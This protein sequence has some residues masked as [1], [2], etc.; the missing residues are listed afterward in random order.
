MAF[1]DGAEDPSWTVLIKGSPVA[2]IKL[3]DQPRAEEIAE[4]FTKDEYAQNVA[5]ALVQCG[6]K[7]VLDQVKA[8]Y[9][10]NKIEQSELAVRMYKKA[11]A[12]LANA[13]KAALAT[14]K[15]NFKASIAT[16]LAGMNRN[17]WQ[18]AENPL[19][20]ALFAKLHDEL[21]ISDPTS[22]IE[23]AFEVSAN[24][25]FDIVL[26]KAIEFM[27]KT[28]EAREEIAQAIGT[29]NPVRATAGFIPAA[30]KLAQRLEGNNIVAQMTGS[31]LSGKDKTNIKNIIRLGKSYN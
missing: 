27:A 7:E 29:S 15:E 18:D 12:E 30:K 23:S 4:I 11:K 16:V 1:Y 24:S 8:R 31:G 14:M 28:P 5:K 6:P 21:G 19:K 26:D 13:Q 10:A 25:Y 22:I 20:S 9:F 3:S 17:F 2:T